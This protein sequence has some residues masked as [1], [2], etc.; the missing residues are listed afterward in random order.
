MRNVLGFSMALAFSFFAG[1]TFYDNYDIDLMP[2]STADIESSDDKASSSSKGKDTLYVINVGGSSDS[3]SS[4]SSF[5]EVPTWTCG[6][7]VMVRGGV[8]YETVEIAGVCITKKNLNYKPLGKANSMC[9][10]QDDAKCEIYG[11]LYDY[12]AASNACP[13]GW[14]LLTKDD[15]E[16]FL[17]YTGKDLDQAG[18]NF[19]V[20]GA[21]QGEADDGDDAI[22]FS[23]LPGGWCDEEEC[24]SEGSYGLWWTSTE[25][26]MNS[27]HVTLVLIGDANYVNISAG[28]ENNQYAYVRCA[29][30]K[31]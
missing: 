6:D 24:G 9:Y 10:D 25:T 18:I 30:K 19:K 13:E 8:E 4:S 11:R 26:E 29:W 12:E 27:T 17:A 28:L 7:S 15:L 22:G 16:R 2:S 20:P 1:C 14:R 5:S 21:W 3:K 31:Q 23:A